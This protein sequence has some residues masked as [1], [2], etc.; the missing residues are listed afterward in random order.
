MSLAMKVQAQI[1]RQS[2]PLRVQKEGRKTVSIKKE[3]GRITK[4]NLV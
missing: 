1:V 3:N 4:E 2:V